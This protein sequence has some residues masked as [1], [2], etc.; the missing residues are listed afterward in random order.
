MTASGGRKVGGGGTEQKGRRTH[1]HGQQRG[2]CWEE[3]D[4]RGLNGK[5]K[6]TILI[7]S[8][9]EYNEQTEKQA[10]ETQIHRCRT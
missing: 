4:I 7:H 8:Y 2:D 6:N 10:K 5:G 9:V 1:E 3:V